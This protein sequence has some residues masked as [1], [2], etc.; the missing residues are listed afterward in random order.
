MEIGVLNGGSSALIL[1]AIKDIENSKLY[2]IDYFKYTLD[3]NNK[4]V[5][6]VVNEYHPELTNKWQ[7]Y[8]GG[9]AS[10]FIE[11]IGGDIDLCFIDSA[12]MNPGEIL[13]YIMVLPFL[14]KNAIVI[15]HDI[16]LHILSRCYA[17]ITNC[18]LFSAIKGKKYYPATEDFGMGVANIGA[19]VLDDNSIDNIFDIFILLTLYWQYIPTDKDYE[20]IIKLISKHYDESL[21]NIFKKTYNKRK[22][23][24]SD[25]TLKEKELE[26]NIKKA[27]DK[28][29]LKKN[30]ELVKNNLILDF[31][32]KNNKIFNNENMDLAL[33]YEKEGHNMQN[34][35]LSKKNK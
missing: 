17:R 2:S 12:H 33:L 13:D 19:V 27:V 18:V 1:N 11:K 9:L 6:W 35:K 8:S 14:K 23:E 24:L 30:K 16:S 25:M 31:L 26:D 28:T 34:N 7:I 20:S 4:E 22:E 10:D 32:I 29:F 3:D 21:I 5:G 15:L